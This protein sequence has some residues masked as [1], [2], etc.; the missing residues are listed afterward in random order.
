MIKSNSINLVNNSGI[1]WFCNSNSSARICVKG[2]AFKGKENLKGKRFSEALVP[3]I[4]N[5]DTDS[6]SS[7]I[8]RTIQLL[9]GSFTLVITKEDFVFAAVDCLRS[10]PL[11]YG[12]SENAF[13]LSD[14]AYWLKDQVGDSRI[15][16]IASK[17]FLLTGYVTGQETLSSNVKQLQAG[18]CLWVTKRDGNSKIT[19]QRYYRYVHH[20]F[21]NASEKELYPKIDQ[22]LVNVFERL[23]E[24]TKGRT[25]VIP[26][27]G[28]I[29]SG[30]IA[31]MLRRLGRENIIC[32]SYGRNG[33]WESEISK[34]VA[35]K[36]GY[37][38][39]FVHYTGRKWYQWFQ[40][41]ERRDYYRFADGLSSLAHIQDWPAVW[42]LKRTEKIPSDAIFVPGH[43]VTLKLAGRPLKGDAEDTVNS[44]LKKHYSLWNWSK[45]S[46]KLGPIFRE[47]VLSQLS[48]ISIDTPEDA[49]NAFECWEWQERQAKFIVNSCRVYEFW[50]YDWRIP[51]WDSEMMDFF[52]HVP[53]AMRLNK[54][55]YNNYVMKRLFFNL[56]TRN[57]NALLLIKDLIKKT[58][59]YSRLLPIYIHYYRRKKEYSSHPL[60]WYG[61]IPRQK[62]DALFTGYENINSFLTM[63][64]LG[65]VSFDL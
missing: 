34:K 18:E 10:I 9:N 30:L 38:W 51:L 40:S 55:L 23:L 12:T 33:N 52:S 20:D 22:I 49:A 44:I 15:G 8:K 31:T 28:G 45:K 19:T 21:F 57:R 2:F 4:E 7:Y 41:D 50:G 62:F 61:A 59:F 3:N 16:E 5:L 53:L 56:E 64:R 17:E 32:F 1:E 36:L 63:E 54:K 37:P 60:R 47:R 29:D 65:K 27:S 58:P 25:L 11:F 43:T 48:G 26:L 24:S 35:D 6:I 14:D 39:E 46:G 42:E 13:Y